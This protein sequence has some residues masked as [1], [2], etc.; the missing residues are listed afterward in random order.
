MAR[1]RVLRK[2]LCAILAFGW[3]SAAVMSDSAAE[4]LRVG[5]NGNAEVVQISAPKTVIEVTERFAKSIQFRE[6]VKRVDA[7]DP[8]IIGVTA[9]SEH[10]LRVQSIQQGVTTM[11]VTDENDVHYTVEVFVSGDA[12]ELQAVLKRAYPNT[13]VIATKAKDAVMLRGWVSEPQQVSEIQALAEVYFPRVLNQ[14]KVG[15]PQE[16]QLRVKLME[17]QRTRVRNFGLNWNYVGKNAAIASTPNG[18]APLSAFAAPVGGPLSSVIS[19]NS[20]T[21]TNTSAAFGFVNASNGFETFIQALKDEGLLK[22]HAETIL[23]TRNGEGAK[24]VNG[25]KFPIPIPQ[26]LG[27][28][29]IDFQDFGVT[30][31][32]LPI[33]V[34]PTRLRQQIHVEVSEKD[35]SGAVTISGTTVPG[36]TT[37]FIE[38]QVEMNFGETLVIGGL[39]YTRLK[40]ETHKTP[41]LGELPGIGAAFRRV[42]YDESEAELV[43]LITPEYTASL[44]NDQI[45]PGGPGLFTAVPTDHELYCDGVLEVPAYDGLCPPDGYPC[46][47]GGSCPPGAP[48]GGPTP[49][50][51]AISPGRPGLPLPSP[52]GPGMPAGP[53]M[54]PTPAPGSNAPLIQPPLVDPGLIVP[55]A[56][57][58]SPEIE[59]QS[60]QKKSGAWMNAGGSLAGRNESSERF[61]KTAQKQKASPKPRNKVEPAEYRSRSGAPERDRVEPAAGV[62]RGMPKATR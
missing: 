29:A 19:N 56:P 7:F 22:I 59:G 49:Y 39:I 41:F 1:Y 53:G 4:E 50:G 46:P 31:E 23:V 48:M 43:V 21:F 14:M 5:A 58:A 57:P 36:L 60:T 9:L 3:L 20:T 8:T 61:P 13:A 51:S 6:R 33:V 44:P 24:L 34:S 17:V 18:L 54:T 45:P 55:P 28:V 25:G 11:T 2:V 30:L 32:S 26:G 16:V 10:V 35:L 47:P 15:G 37:R 27:T 62:S 40:G 42:N 38:S 12:R 52:G